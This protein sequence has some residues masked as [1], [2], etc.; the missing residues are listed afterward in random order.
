VLR[1]LHADDELPDVAALDDEAAAAVDIVPLDADDAAAWMRTLT[2]VRLVLATRLG[3][4]TDDQVVD[5]PRAF[6]YDW[7]GMLLDGIV[8]A[9]APDDD[10]TAS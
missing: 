7:L 5:D 3:I 6:L 9:V 2:A 10:V 1:S 4:E 8:R